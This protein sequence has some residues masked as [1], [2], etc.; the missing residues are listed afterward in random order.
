LLAQIPLGQIG[1]GGSAGALGGA[2]AT[3]GGGATEVDREETGAD[4]ALL[5]GITGE[6]CF[7]GPPTTLDL[8]FGPPTEFCA[9]AGLANAQSTR[10]DMTALL[11]MDDF[12]FKSRRQS[13][14]APNR[15]KDKRCR[16][17]SRREPHSFSISVSR[18][19]RPEGTKRFW[20]D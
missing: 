17:P 11:V 3:F 4:P 7:T 2:E 1:F 8:P 15:R 9:K 16:R 19:F 13:K 18:R 10:I 12:P 6:V 14:I 20:S 5:A